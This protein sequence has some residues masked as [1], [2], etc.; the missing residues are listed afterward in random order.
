[1]STPHPQPTHE[2]PSPS[3]GEGFGV[4]G[5][6][7][8]LIIVTL[9]ALPLLTYPLG[10]DQG[11]Y[12]N[13][14]RNILEGG[15]PFV[16][17]W[18]I[19]PPAI[20]YVYAAAIGL[21]GGGS[22]PIRALDLV[23]VPL[24]MLAIYGIGV[25]VGRSV[26]VGWLAA[27]MF[28]V[29]YFTETFASLSQSDSLVTLPMAWA[30]LATFRAGDAGRGSRAA[31]AWALMAGALAALTIWFKHYYALFVLALVIEHTLRRM[32]DASSGALWRR[33]PL[34]EAGAFALG[35]LPVGGIPLA[36]FMLNGVWDE[37]LIVAAGTAAYNQQAQVSF[38][39]FVE[40]FSGYLVFRWQHW[41]VLIVAALTWPFAP[42]VTRRGWRGVILWLM[43]GLAFVLVQGKGFDTHWIPMLPPLALMGAAALDGWIQA[44]TARRRMIQRGVYALVVAGLLLILVK[45]TWIRAWPYLTGQQ[46]QV[47]YYRHFQGNDYKAWE[48]LRVVNW[49]KQRTTSGDTIFIWG[50]RPEI[51]YLSDLRPATRYQAHFPLVA[52]W[53]PSEW[54]A[55]NVEQLWAA[56]PPY[57]LVLQADYLP[58][59][60]GRAE[61]SATL[62][63]FEEHKPLE[64]WLIYNYDRLQVMGDFIVWQRKN[65]N[66]GQASNGDGG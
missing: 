35:G 53:W 63:T 12:A 62:L 29:F 61:D 40:Q 3:R 27:L 41:G 58:W 38:S 28:A 10:R 42:R 59:V 16:D 19:K 45:D 52:S 39:A 57:V 4:R 5:L 34:K 51:A 15:T 36:A 47:R 60:T 33:F 46:T 14:A 9:A 24:T 13:I 11:M 50:F 25:R 31:L 37:M 32:S 26:R 65:L 1:M 17:M 8:L 66:S 20:Y 64:N 56:L 22:A 7:L 44:V 43:A 23:A 6:L 55:Q 30:A 21:L 2:S 18:D 54:R 48:S 49:L